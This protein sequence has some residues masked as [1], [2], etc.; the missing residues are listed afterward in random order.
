MTKSFTCSIMTLCQKYSQW[1]VGMSADE[2]KVFSL[3]REKT[4][5]SIKDVAEKTGRTLRTIY[6][7]ENGDSQPDKMATDMLQK[8]AEK[9]N[10]TY[11]SK[12]PTFSFI[13]LFAG[14]GGMRLGFEAVGGKC[15]FTSEWNKYSRQTYQANFP[16][17]HP[18]EGDITKI[19]AKEIQI[20]RAHV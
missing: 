10:T 18:M 6:R 13:D 7:W 19:P 2:S 5:L 11:S 9:V 14:I 15:I 4:G 20:G 8:I 16:I 12:V 1:R 17:D 3:L